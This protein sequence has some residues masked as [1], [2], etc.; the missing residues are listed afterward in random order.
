MDRRLNDMREQLDGKEREALEHQASINRDFAM[1]N[2]RFVPRREL[3][4]I[5]A[6]FTVSTDHIKRDVHNQDK[7]L[8]KIID[9]ID[10]IAGNDPRARQ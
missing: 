5:L 4:A 7:K 3:E 8:D 6:T 9:K 1:L 10:R 2:D